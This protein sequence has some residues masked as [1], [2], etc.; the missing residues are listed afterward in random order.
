M[1]KLIIYDLDGTLAD[2]REDIACA[3]NHML[4]QLEKKPLPQK[5]IKKYV[6]QGLHHLIQHCLNEKDPKTVEKGAKIYRAYYA[7]HMLDHTALYPDAVKVLEHFRHVKQAVITNKPNPFTRDILRALNVL[8]YFVEVVAGDSEY[9]KKPDPAAVCAIMK[10]EGILPEESVFIGDSSIDIETA[11]RAG[12]ETVVITHG[13]TEEDEL[14]CAA[15]DHIVQDFS[16]LLRLVHA[17]G[18]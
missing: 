10:R 18:W 16:E 17:K 11:R 12:I 2:T 1:K 6:G 14:R 15:P 4:H 8:D 7:E 9:P 5:I 13:F 3:V